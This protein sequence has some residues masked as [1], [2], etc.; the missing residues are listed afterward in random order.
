MDRQTVRCQ[1]LVRI[2]ITRPVTR[3]IGVAER[4]VVLES[5]L[6]SCENFF[7][8]LALGLGVG[9]HVGPVLF[10]QRAFQSLVAK[11]IFGMATKM[12][13]ESEMTRDLLAAG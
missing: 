12:I 8:Q 6:C 9:I 13:P 1:A 11:A 2:E 10:R 4:F 7:H 5:V 3:L